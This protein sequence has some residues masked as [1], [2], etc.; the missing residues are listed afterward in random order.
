M[1]REI[2]KNVLDTSKELPQWANRDASMD[3]KLIIDS[4]GKP[5]YV[6]ARDGKWYLYFEYSSNMRFTM[7]RQMGM[8]PQLHYS[9]YYF[10]AR[11]ACRIP[12]DGSK[13]SE[14]AVPVV[15]ALVNVAQN[16][17]PE[18]IEVKDGYNKYI[19]RYKSA[20]FEKTK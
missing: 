20:F 3:A 5:D 19:S 6:C 15:S 9:R 1:F 13:L 7:M 18:A 16:K 17:K 2:I 11:L 14:N 8:K 10:P 12:V 4:Y